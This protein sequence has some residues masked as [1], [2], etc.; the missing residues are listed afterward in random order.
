MPLI[1]LDQI[2]LPLRYTSGSGVIEVITDNDKG[3]SFTELIVHGT[4]TSS[5]SV[6]IVDSGSLGGNPLDGGSF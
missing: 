1:T 5:G 4:T 2:Y 6:N 3:A